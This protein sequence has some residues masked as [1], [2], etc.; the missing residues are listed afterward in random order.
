MQEKQKMK[1]TEVILSDR[2]IKFLIDLMWGC[3]ISIVQ[4]T[5]VRHQVSD[6]ELEQL[7]SMH[8]GNMYCDT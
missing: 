8:L 6:T 4:Q 5:A 3:P 2:Q 7:L 1:Q